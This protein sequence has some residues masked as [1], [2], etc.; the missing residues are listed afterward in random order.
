MSLNPSLPEALQE[1]YLSAA[2]GLPSKLPDDTLELAIVSVSSVYDATSSMS[3]VVPTI[4]EAARGKGIIISNV[5]GSTAGGVLGSLS[6]SPLEVEG[7]PC[8]SVTLASLPSVSLN[9]F[10]VA[11]GDVPDQGYDYTDEEWRK[12]LGDVMMMGDEKVGK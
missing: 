11:E 10:H 7:A 4:V 6:G 1:A 2:A 9:A 5:I 8:V 3:I 12:Y